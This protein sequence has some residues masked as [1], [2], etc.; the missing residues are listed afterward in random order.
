MR[1]SD[2][3]GWAFCIF[4]AFVYASLGYGSPHPTP[5]PRL[6]SRYFMFQNSPKM[7][8]CVIEVKAEVEANVLVCV[9]WTES[10]PG[11]EW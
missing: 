3:D 2:F 9:L 11:V 10:Y 5:F 6:P 7:G 4:I 8:K 1:H